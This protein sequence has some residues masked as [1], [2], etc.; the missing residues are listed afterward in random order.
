MLPLST[1]TI[2][3]LVD[4]AFAPLKVQLRGNIHPIWAESNWDSRKR[5]LQ[6][7]P[8]A[9]LATHLLK[10][11]PAEFFCH[12]A[13]FGQLLPIDNEAIRQTNAKFESRDRLDS[14]AKLGYNLD[15]YD[16]HAVR[17]KLEAVAADVRQ[18]SKHFR[19]MPW[20]S[21]VLTRL[22]QKLLPPP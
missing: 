10:T 20:S 9:R 13:L 18:V 1:D 12:L 14:V 2:N 16:Q 15:G 19:S 7:A 5:F 6:V 8:A 4:D 3:S 11:V 17:A 22:N 21:L